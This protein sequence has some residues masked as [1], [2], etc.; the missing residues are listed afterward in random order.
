MRIAGFTDAATISVDIAG[1]VDAFLDFGF[2][3]DAR[4]H[5]ADALDGDA[6]R[7]FMGQALAAGVFAL[8]R[9]VSGA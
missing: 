5:G 4:S 7:R 3:L 9:D 6:T 1:D 8:A 2:S